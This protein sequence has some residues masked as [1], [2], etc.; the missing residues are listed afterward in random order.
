M[1]YT[2][3]ELG[4]PGNPG[5]PDIFDS[6]ATLVCPRSHKLV[7]QVSGQAVMLQFGQLRAGAGVSGVGNIQWGPEEQ[8]L[9]ISGTLTRRFDAVRVRNYTLEKAA[10]V[11]MI[12]LNEDD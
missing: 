11:V 9:P 6:E 3:L 1:S 2:P 10:Q 5:V 7:L 4:Q 8:Y 12:A